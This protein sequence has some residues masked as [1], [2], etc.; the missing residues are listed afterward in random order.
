MTE[1]TTIPHD[2]EAQAELDQAEIDDMIAVPDDDRLSLLES[3]D[4]DLRRIADRVTD[5]KIKLVTAKEEASQCKKSLDAALDELHDVARRKLTAGPLFDGPPQDE[6]RVVTIG[7][8]TDHGVTVAQVSRLLEK[9]PGPITTLGDLADFTGDGRNRLADIDGIGAK[10]AESIE[11]AIS[12]WF[13]ANPDKC[14]PIGGSDD[15][16]YEPVN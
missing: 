1:S 5:L 4:H 13:G 16:E 9:T 14:P 15:D 8:L 11:D 3:H 2:P 7:E 12:K 6:W 10:A